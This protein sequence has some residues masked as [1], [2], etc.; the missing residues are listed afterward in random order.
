[1]QFDSPTCGGAV[2]SCTDPPCL[3]FQLA[4]YPCW[5]EGTDMRSDDGDPGVETETRQQCHDHVAAL[6]ATDPAYR[7]LT[8]THADMA[9][10]AKV[11]PAGPGDERPTD[12]CLIPD[13]LCEERQG[14]GGPR[15]NK[16][17]F[18]LFPLPIEGSHGK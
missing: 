18:S 10:N 8:W 1:M 9:G 12:H 7:G 14:V 4:R 16:G 5:L 6:R 15:I 17:G 2:L 3:N 13:V 11:L